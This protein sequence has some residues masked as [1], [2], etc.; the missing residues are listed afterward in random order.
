MSDR[1]KIALVIEDLLL[2]RAVEIAAA[3]SV[4]G[5]EVII[6]DHDFH[7]LMREEI[8]R[9]TLDDRLK[10]DIERKMPV[11]V[12]R[13][14]IDERFERRSDRPRDWEQRNKPRKRRR[15]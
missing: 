7:S 13:Y 3:H 8:V 11:P 6:V 14:A 5:S 4:D 9:M 1:T 12:P 10:A 2:T 15:R